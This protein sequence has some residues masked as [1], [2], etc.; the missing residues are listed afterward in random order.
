MNPPLSTVKRRNLKRTV[1]A[2]CSDLH[3]GHRY[4][5]LNPDTVLDEIDETG[6]VIDQYNPPLTKIQEYL[7]KI[8]TSQIKSIGEYAAG[9]DLIVIMNGDMT[10]GNKHHNMFVSDRI[11]DQIIIGEYNAYPWYELNPRA[12]RIV[13]GTGAHTFGEGS[14]ELVI[15]RLLQAKFP[16][17]STKVTDHSLIN[18]S[19]MDVDIAHHGP[20]PGSREWLKGNEARYYLRSLMQQEIV[21]G[22]V[23]PRLVVRGHYH[24]EIEE[25][26]IVKSNGNRYKSTLV[27]TPSFTFL[28]HYTRQAV[29]SP[30][31]IT[32]GMLMV[33][34]VDGE[35]LRSVPMTKTID[36]RTK[37][38]L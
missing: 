32:H 6:N 18:I 31:R 36:V 25:T 19:G 29:K 33:E 28:D 13:K 15:G 26:L 37:E 24:E 9:D 4:G 16:S 14:S 21:A 38:T 1:L 2:V 27:I 12:V 20:P 10:I 30:S 17:M 23:P 5:L 35:I 3:G 22:K 8:Y 34:I 11:S 7:W